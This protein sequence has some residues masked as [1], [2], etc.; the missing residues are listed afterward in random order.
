MNLKIKLK[1]EIKDMGGRA[2]RTK[3]FQEHLQKIIKDELGE[4]VAQR[5][6]WEL[7]KA[8]IFGT[9]QFTANDEENKLP[10]A[11]VGRFEVL[12][13][14]PRGRKKEEDWE[15]TPKWRFYPSAKINQ[16]LEQE[17]G[18]EDHDADLGSYGLFNEAE[19]IGG[20]VKDLEESELKDEG[21][22]VSEDEIDVDKEDEEE[23][24]EEEIN[25]EFDIDIDLDGLDN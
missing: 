13:T 23:I 11:G 4:V 15:F 16:W 6:A 7:F 17:F 25:K 12:K 14:V 20:E 22:K 18:M 24:S 19:E 10:L 3:K 2:P 1:E 8:I 9:V 5:D 21:Q